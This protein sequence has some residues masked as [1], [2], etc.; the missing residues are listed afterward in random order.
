MLT[1]FQ[2]NP[3]S[4]SVF[5]ARQYYSW[6]PSLV[7]R[8]GIGKLHFSDVT[9]APQI[10]CNS[11]LCS[12]ACSCQ[13]NENKTSKLLTTC[14]SRKE[15]TGDQW[16][17]SQRAS[18]AESVPMSWREHVNWCCSLALVF[19]GASQISWLQSNRHHGQNGIMCISKSDYQSHSS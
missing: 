4:V 18:I 16:F 8:Q 10:A 19:I 11:N 6:Q 5:C 9:W 12:T 3:K 2:Y 7:N 17:P 1:F 15:S 13:N 14:P